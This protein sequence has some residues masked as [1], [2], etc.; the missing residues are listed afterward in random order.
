MVYLSQVYEEARQAIG[1]TDSYQG[2][3]DT[4]ATSGTA[5]EFSAAQ[6]AGRLESKR[7]L[8]D[9]AYAQLFEAM[10][11]FK[12]AYAD[13]PRPVVSYDNHGRAEYRQFNRYDF[14]DRDEAGN[15]VWNDRF[16]F[17]CDT[18]APLAS[19][20]EA[21]WQ[22]TRMNLQ[23]GAFGDPAN[24]QT[25][26]L[27]WTKMEMLHYPGAGETKSYLEEELQRQQLQQQQM[28]QV[29]MQMQRQQMQV[30]QAQAQAETVQNV[31]SQARKDAQQ[32]MSA[33]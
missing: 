8:K 19:N 13:E 9:A 3:K 15:W 29:Q 11:K 4:T 33:R 22:E 7:V 6:A 2:R 32:T 30:Q 14:L 27:F 24:L 10:F 21:M 18:S 26:I 1:I 20:R 23:T 17:S 16:L 12:L 28:M 5:K 25:L 31:V